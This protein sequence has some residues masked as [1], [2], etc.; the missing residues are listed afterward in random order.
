MLCEA[1][2]EAERVLRVP[3]RG[4]KAGWSDDILRELFGLLLG[5][6]RQERMKGRRRKKPIKDEA[7]HTSDPRTD[8][9]AIMRIRGDV[10]SGNS[11]IPAAIKRGIKVSNI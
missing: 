4:W 11:A 2:E 7:L 9:V 5:A 10:R 8:Q 6:R 3:L 1:I